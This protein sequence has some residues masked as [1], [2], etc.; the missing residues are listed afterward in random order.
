MSKGGAHY[1]TGM[2]K[3]DGAQQGGN[4]FIDLQEGCLNYD[5]KRLI[6]E[7]KDSPE[8]LPYHK[9]FKTTNRFTEQG[10]SRS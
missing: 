5:I 7:T 9:K 1:W 4:C 8:R 2:N 6:I 3:V 10:G